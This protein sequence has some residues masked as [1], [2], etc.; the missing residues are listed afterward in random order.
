MATRIN[1]PSFSKSKS[2]ELYKQ[3]LVAWSE[4]TDLDKK[5][6]GIAVALTLPED[7]ESKIR[8]KVFDQID[9]E[10][11]KKD[12][13]FTTLVEILDKHL[14]KDD[15]ADSLEKFKI[16]KILQDPKSSQRGAKNLNPKGPD[17]KPFKTCRSCGSYGHLVAKCPDSWENLSKVNITEEEEHAVYSLVIKNKTLNG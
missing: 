4:I 3:E 6:R 7:D 9:L 16:L 14:A 17:G 15:L 1:L 10:D 12:T 8:E 5:K 2:Y 13:G 11:L